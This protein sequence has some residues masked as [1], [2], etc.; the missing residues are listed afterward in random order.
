M[1]GSTGLSTV[2]GWPGHEHQW[3]GSTEP[4]QGRAEDIA[5]VYS[6]QD[7]SLAKLILSKYDISYV[8]IS[9]Q[10]KAS[11]PNLSEDKFL[12]IGDLVFSREKARIYRVSY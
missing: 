10:E 6:T 5:T 3:R 8:V 12:E 9:P 4:L 2:L 11:Y 7:P 1:S